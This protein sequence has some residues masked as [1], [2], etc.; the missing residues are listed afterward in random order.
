MSLPHPLSIFP[1]RNRGRH[2]ALLSL[3]SAIMTLT[4][5]AQ[6]P[7]YTTTGNLGTG[8]NV[9][10]FGSTSSQKVQSPY[11]PG[12]IVGAYAGNITKVYWQ[13]G[14]ATTASITYTDLTISMALV[15]ASWVGTGTY[16]GPMT[17]VY[18]ASS[19]TVPAT[20]IDTWFGFTLNTPF[21]Y[22][23][24]MAL[25]V[26]VCHNGYTGTG[27]SIR[28]ASVTPPAVRRVYGATCSAAT[29]STDALHYALGIDMN[30]ALP[31]D[32]G[33]STL[34]A[35]TNFCGGTQDIQVNLKNYGT[36]ALNNVT[37]NWTYDNVAQTPIAYTTPIPTLGDATIT[38]GSRPF[39]SGVAHSLKAWTSQPN[40]TTDAFPQ[41][42]TLVATIK[43]SLF[44]TFT[45]GGA[46]PDY[47]TV[48]AAANDI[49][50][51]GICGP[52]V[53]KIRNGTYNERVNIGNVP[54]ASSTNTITFESESGNRS[55]VNITFASTAAADNGT[56]NIS[57][58]DYVTVRNLTVSNT[59][60]TYSQVMVVQG[61]AEN[62]T[63]ENL[64][65]IG[66]NVTSGGT[67]AVVL[68]SPSGSLDHNMVVRNCLIQGGYYGTYLYGS[69][70]ASL[71]NNMVFENNIV[72]N[73]YY[74]GAYFY[75]HNTPIIR[76]NIIRTTNTGTNYMLYLGYCQNK[77]IV[78]GNSITANGGGG[79]K[80]GMYI[81]YNTATAGNEGITANNFITIVNGTGTAY[82]MYPYYSN[83]QKIYH[84]TVY[85][86]S[87]TT[88]SRCIYPYYGT[89]YDLK[90]NIFYMDGLG[91]AMY[92]ATNP[93]SNIS[94][95][96]YNI[97]YTNGAALAYYNGLDRANLAALQAASL[98]DGNSKSK[99]VTFANAAAGNL[100]LAGASEND[101]DLN[102]SLMADVTDDIDG[103]PRV[104]PY[105]GA[106]EAC[107]I[108][109]GSVTFD[110]V[111][112]SDQPITYANI[113]VNM[114][115]R[116]HV[117]FP[118]FASTVTVTVNF[119]SIPANVLVYSTNFSVSKQANLPLDG[120][121]MITVGPAVVPGVYRVEAVINTKN[122]CGGYRLVTPPNKSLYVVPTGQNLCLV[123]PGDV[124]NDGLVNYADRKALNQ[125]IQDANLRASWLQGPMRYRADASVNPM[126]YLS[127]EG[128][129]GLPWTTS[130]GCFMD[131]DGNGYVN[132]L[133]YLGM[134]INW[135]RQHLAAPK[136]APEG[137]GLSFDMSQNYPN[138]FN[139][140]TTIQ[141]TVPER[142][143]VRLVVTDLLGREI[144]TLVN[145]E[146]EAG[147]H[148]LQFGRPGLQSGSYIAVVTMTGIESGTT[149]SKTIKMTLAK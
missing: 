55:L 16:Y 80:Y 6:T 75:Y 89:Y 58:A 10:P 77:R 44:G 140:T 118:A 18:Y 94:A 133:D 145:G 28:N 4:A 51:N 72:E 109:T 19:I 70:T 14:S 15:P 39:A 126:T 42:D 31:N 60:T 35:P 7:Q 105:I 138:P 113:P 83:Y 120:Y 78:T 130:D 121:Q 8:A 52:V 82:A 3:L 37:I 74:Y 63:L 33:I 23:P 97:F 27:K 54:G 32:A 106:D 62:C 127:W 66:P 2:L 108:P 128:Q 141:V 129:A 112:S 115:V 131:V 147:T 40:S 95:S 41:N 5:L 20:P 65:L 86:N 36:N 132:A 101:T 142:A 64:N 92:N 117:D 25:I 107:Y 110:L 69:G 12:E 137:T 144:E 61:G 21:Y 87:S 57:G 79:T 81:Y 100:H 149:Y 139:P 99:Q 73:F 50:T 119:Y 26:T 90:D 85:V 116:Y 22:N 56:F 84:N 122:S 104:I 13:A 34:I 59:G 103:E 45:I 46:T 17:Q 125:Y 93:N 38:L 148:P 47:A 114:G 143:Q 102:G 9:F 124:N 30:P 88:A 1:A 134:K 123:W 43:P 53:F 24:S 11:Y 111:N 136:D 49:S 48:A 29:G 71:E 98:M 67:T 76:N 91:Y 146:M 96:N 68:Y 135:M